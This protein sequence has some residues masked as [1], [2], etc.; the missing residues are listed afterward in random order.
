MTDVWPAELR[1]LLERMHK[2][3][4][5]PAHLLRL[6]LPGR[7]LRCLACGCQ[8]F[9]QTSRD[10]ATVR[11]GVVT[12]LDCGRRWRIRGFAGAIDEMGFPHM[13]LAEVRETV[14]IRME[15]RARVT[16]TTCQQER[17]EA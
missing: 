11:Q 12:C 5:S 10:L 14:R 16:G 15:E 13:R 3:A 7:K 17:K 2:G 1:E 4:Y 8:D 9:A 6:D